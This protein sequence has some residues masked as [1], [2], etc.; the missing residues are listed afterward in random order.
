MARYTISLATFL[1]NYYL[2][3]RNILSNS[4][5]PNCY[6]FPMKHMKYMLNYCQCVPQI[7]PYLYMNYMKYMMNLL[8]FNLK[9]HEIM[10]NMPN[11]R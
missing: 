7:V 11:I 8:E 3:Y 10:S 6:H 9:S 4:L 5:L 2:I 1:D